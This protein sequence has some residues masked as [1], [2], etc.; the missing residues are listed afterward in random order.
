MFCKY[1]GKQIEDESIFCPYCGQK[2]TDDEVA[3][4][5][6]VSQK[7]QESIKQTE[8]KEEPQKQQE[9]TKVIEEKPIETVEEKSESKTETVS[10]KPQAQKAPMGK[11]QVAIFSVF[12]AVILLAIIIA[13]VA[14]F[15]KKTVDPF[16]DM[17]PVYYGYN[18]YGYFNLVN[19]K[20]IDGEY[21]LDATEHYNFIALENESEMLYRDMFG[22]S[23]SKEEDLSKAYAFFVDG[24]NS[25]VVNADY[26]G[27][28]QGQLSNGDVVVIT[29]DYDKDLFDRAG[30]KLSKT[31]MEYT[32]EGLQ[33]LS[34]ADL[35]ANVEVAW[36]NNYGDYYIQIKE[37]E[38]LPVDYSL[39]EIGEVNNG[40][41]TVSL[42]AEQI[43]NMYG[44]KPTDGKYSKDFNVGSQPVEVKE[45]NES[46]ISQLTDLATKVL[47]EVYINKCG[48][49][50]YNKDN[51]E[52]ITSKELTDIRYS[53]GEFEATFNVST[54][55]GGTYKKVIS[56]NAMIDSNGE[57][58]YSTNVDVDRLGCTIE[59]GTWKKN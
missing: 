12:G 38:N 42:P 15:A 58:Q 47:N 52:L 19:S 29:L 39:Y 4:E 34:A 56:F 53:W 3:E 46:N 45:V 44:L 8:E 24:V 37:N 57:Y 54:D 51:L 2:L 30:Y 6:E 23:G 59:R 33:E 26:A 17:T 48:W 22:S 16:E 31:S 21:S 28:S 1:C 41:V 14:I 18:D 5:K 35:F 50:L 25:I 10:L 13:C 40:T 32:V 36:V 7:Q 43:A 49:N 27:K 11:K 20:E 9:Q 55:A